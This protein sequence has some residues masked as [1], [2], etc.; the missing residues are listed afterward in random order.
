M[1]HSFKCKYKYKYIQKMKLQVQVQI[2][3][4]IQCKLKCKYIVDTHIC[5]YKVIQSKCYL[6]ELMHS[7]TQL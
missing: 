6:T 3:I 7:H 5:H 4:Q 2:Q 1:V